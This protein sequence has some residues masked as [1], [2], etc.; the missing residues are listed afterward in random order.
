MEALIQLKEINKS[1][2][3]TTVLDS[4]SLDFYP[5][6]VHAVLGCNG[7]GKSTLVKIIAGIIKPDSGN[8]I[9]D[10]AA[11]SFQGPLEA[12]QKGIQISTQELQLFDN[13]TIE[14]NLF[15]RNEITY[16]SK[17]INKKQTLEK[18]RETLEKLKINAQPG[19]MVGALS[20]AEKYLVQFARCV[21]REPRVLVVD[22]LAASL[23][24]REL[25]IVHSMLDD[26][27]ANGAAI[28]YITHRVKETKEI[29]DVV[30]V[31]KDGR[32][33]SGQIKN[34]L[35]DDNLAQL[36]LGKSTK[37]QY[38]KLP[39][40]LKD[41]ILDVSHI[42]NRFIDDISFT[43]RRGEV[44][45]IAGVAGSGRS[46]VLNAIAGLDKISSGTI[47]YAEAEGKR[48]RI[49]YLPENRDTQALFRNF[50]V[51]RNITIKNLKRVCKR[52]VIDL[53]AESISCKDVIDRL[54]IDP[55]N[56]KRAVKHLSG[57]NKQ[58]VIISRYLFSKCSIYL[59]DE[60]T[61]GIDIAGKVEVYN[62]INELARKG[63]GIILVSSDYSELM[64]MCDRIIIMKN[65][66]VAAEI[67]TSES[68]K[69]DIFD[70]IY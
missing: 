53:R 42:S 50:D 59:F 67:D 18:T 10:G 16:S 14:D 24:R 26:L 70:N 19:R 38:P 44:L 30:S 21:L 56:S 28:I 25:D 51:V 66:R 2:Y 45:G 57:G 62:I 6:S 17:F 4:V 27:K 11:V 13:M 68:G 37:E 49:G 35:P 8:I 64:G 34:Y 5:G 69:L 22:E 46:K 43:L 20:H 36:M 15:I 23:T 60:P 31:L 12:T 39:V 41:E 7:A 65:G 32:V 58:K 48:D 9:V 3:S 40:K 61:Q 29:S 55:V 1:F 33:V 54:G 52:R 47:S 63:A